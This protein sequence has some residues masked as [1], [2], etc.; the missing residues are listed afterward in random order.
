MKQILNLIKKSIFGK[1][2]YYIRDLYRFPKMIFLIGKIK[3]KS[4]I[5]ILIGTSTFNNLGDHLIS[6]ASKEFI[7]MYI[8]K[9]K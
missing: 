3:K 5:V 6:I 4:D 7:R 1:I 8:M 2:L 9:K